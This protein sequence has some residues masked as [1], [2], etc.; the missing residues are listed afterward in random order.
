MLSHKGTNC[1]DLKVQTSYFLLRITFF[2]VGWLDDCFVLGQ[3]QHVLVNYKWT[4][5]TG[6]GEVQG[7]PSCRSW[8]ESCLTGT[9]QKDVERGK[10]G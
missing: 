8:E 4:R 1:L 3:G 10:G 7:A 6:S 5:Y 9:Y 2:P